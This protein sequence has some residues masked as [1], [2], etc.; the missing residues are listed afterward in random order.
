M[1]NVEKMLRQAHD[2]LYDELNRNVR[3]MTVTE[4]DFI[5]DCLDKMDSWIKDA[6]GKF[7]R[8]DSVKS[9]RSQ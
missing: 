1:K 5:R 4:S 3:E 9:S 6:E 7:K 8:A 2:V